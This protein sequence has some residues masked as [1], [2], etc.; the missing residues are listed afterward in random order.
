MTKI[1]ELKK[2]LMNDTKFRAQYEKAKVEF[3]ELRGVRS[4]PLHQASLGPPPPQA[5]EDG[6]VAPPR[7]GGSFSR[8]RGKVPGR[9]EGGSNKR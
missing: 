3:A 4:T 5:G 1:A 7:H 8:S 2:R 9:A 6:D